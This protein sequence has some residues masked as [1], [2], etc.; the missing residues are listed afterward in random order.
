[1]SAFFSADPTCV[2]GHSRSVF[3]NLIGGGLG[4]DSQSGKPEVR[5]VNTQTVKAQTMATD[6]LNALFGIVLMVDV[7][8]SDRVDQLISGVRTDRAVGG[9]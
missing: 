5:M 8:F 1:M 6:S 4:L 2:I 7:E 9:S 3:T